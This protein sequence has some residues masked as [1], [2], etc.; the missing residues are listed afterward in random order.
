MKKLIL[1]FLAF[2]SIFFILDMYLRPTI[3]NMSENKA[4]TIATEIIDQVVLE[5]LSTINIDGQKLV[6]IEYDNSESISSVSTNAY[7]MNL[8]KT[9]ISAAIQK[10]LS[11]LQVKTLEI[12][13]G[14]LLGTEILNG[15]GPAI[16]VKIS[17]SGSSM[18]EFSSQFSESGINQTKHQVYLDVNTKVTIIIPG[19]SSSSNIHTNIIISEIIIV[20]K[21]PNFYFK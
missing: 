1:L 11:K 15:R 17:M 7:F 18:V 5:E 4:K 20:G 14:T 6:N 8:I 21:V 13:L 2:L 19:H 10:K 16:P 3:K 12:P 9:R